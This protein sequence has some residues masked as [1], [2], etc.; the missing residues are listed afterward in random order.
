MFELFEHEDTGAAGDDKAVA[1]GVIGARCL[2]RRL[3]EA[4]RHGAHGVE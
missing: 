3:V 1:V 2:V 4:R